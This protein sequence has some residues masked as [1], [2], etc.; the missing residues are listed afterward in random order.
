MRKVFGDTIV[1]LHNDGRFHVDYG[2]SLGSAYFKS[3]DEMRNELE[4]WSE[5][6]LNRVSKKMAALMKLRR[7]LLKQ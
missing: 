1:T 3:F 7:W 6:E 4:G 5:D 2:P